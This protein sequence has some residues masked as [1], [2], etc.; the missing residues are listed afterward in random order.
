V[1]RKD[2][3]PA[4]DQLLAD[5]RRRKIDVL[6]CWRLDRLGRN[7]RHLVTLIDEMQAVGVAFVSLN[8]GIDTGRTAAASHSGGDGAVRVGTHSETGS[9]WP[10]A[11]Q[12]AGQ[13]SGSTSAVSNRDPSARCVKGP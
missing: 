10:A 9:G 11:R 3:R 2:R 8:E 4:L 7:L 13:A 12:S 6:L 5:A 1:A